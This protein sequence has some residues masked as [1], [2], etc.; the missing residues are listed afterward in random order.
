MT[1]RNGLSG[2]LNARW[3]KGCCMGPYELLEM[4]VG[5]M[6]RLG[7]PYLCYDIIEDKRTALIA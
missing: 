1:T 2:M 6:D 5:I 4:I 3:Q 7:I